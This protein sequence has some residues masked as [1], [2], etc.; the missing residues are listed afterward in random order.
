MPT[1]ES[2]L[3]C[4]EIFSCYLS[5]NYLTTLLDR[6]SPIY[7]METKLVGLASLNTMHLVKA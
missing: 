5:R 7:I 6:P 4:I 2:K 1:I 3:G